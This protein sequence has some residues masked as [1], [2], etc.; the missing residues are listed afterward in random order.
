MGG[1]N[2]LGNEP[3]NAP[4]SCRLQLRY[5]LERGDISEMG[6][7]SYEENRENVWVVPEDIT[8]QFIASQYCHTPR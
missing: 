5:K 8:R 7:S 2:L 1:L 4:F 6:V 3:R